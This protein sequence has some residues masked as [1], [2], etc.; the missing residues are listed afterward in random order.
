MQSFRHPDLLS[1]KFN[2]NKFNCFGLFDVFNS[3]GIPIMNYATFPIAYDSHLKY[4][5]LLSIDGNAAAWL[6]IPWIMHSNSLLIK[7]E[8]TKVQWFYGGLV[9]HEHYWP[10]DKDLT[11]VIPVIEE[12]KKD[13][14]K[15][16]KVIKNANEFF[17]N[18]L[19]PKV[20]KKA[21]LDIIGAYSIKYRDFAILKRPD[22]IKLPSHSMNHYSFT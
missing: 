19:R 21:F 13:Q 4:K 8:S 9:A 20:I 1:I 15:V 22:D 16:Q 6:R 7:Q 2:F 10:V 18:N 11:D 5:Y 17:E 12:I 14:E 3:M